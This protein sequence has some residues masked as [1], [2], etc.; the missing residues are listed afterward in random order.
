MF[1]RQAAA[2]GLRDW[3]KFNSSLYVHYAPKLRK[4]ISTPYE[5]SV[6]CSELSENTKFSS[7]IKCKN[8]LSISYTKEVGIS[9][10]HSYA[11]LIK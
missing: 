7:N 8:S 2:T 9:L 6:L 10:I 5:F 1:S 4:T 3:A 11:Y